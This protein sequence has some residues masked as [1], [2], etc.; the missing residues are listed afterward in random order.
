VR[1]LGYPRAALLAF[2]T[3]VLAYNVLTVIQ[4]TVEAEHDLGAAGI[5]LSSYFIAANV[6][7]YYAGMIVAVPTTT[8]AT[9]DPQSPAQL[10]SLL[11]SIAVH[12]DPRTLRKHPRKPKPKVR[13]GYA[14]AASAPRHVATA[15]VLREGR[16]Q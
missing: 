2:S 16:V 15:R 9:F 4:A 12:V 13:K 3:A 5:E 11:R 10:S 1:T 8:W 6:K 14:P 7:A